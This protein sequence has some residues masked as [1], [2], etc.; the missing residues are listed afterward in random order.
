M[1]RNFDVFISQGEI[2]MTNN[3]IEEKVMLYG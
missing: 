1:K 3:I 2:R